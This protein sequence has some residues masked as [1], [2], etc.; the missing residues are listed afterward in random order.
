[1]YPA[2]R[3]ELEVKSPPKQ[4]QTRREALCPGAVELRRCAVPD[5]TAIFAALHGI[6]S[7]PPFRHML[8]PGGFRMSVAMTRGRQ[9]LNHD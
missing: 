8:T 2:G 1:L 5:A 4:G 9:T 3:A 7:Q 6:T